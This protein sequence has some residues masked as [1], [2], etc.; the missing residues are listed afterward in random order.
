MIDNDCHARLADLSLITLIPDQTTILPTWIEGDTTPWTSPELLDP[1]SF[2]LE[3]I[4][5]TRESDCYALGMVIYEVL[6]GKAPFSPSV[7]PFLKVLG[8]ERP[9]RPHGVVTDGI[10]EMLQYCWKAQPRDR[11]TAK[12]VLLGLEGKPYQQG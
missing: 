2:G 1:P 4:L 9:E 12:A 11:I 7:A 8:G 10:W 5:P 6:S 3:E